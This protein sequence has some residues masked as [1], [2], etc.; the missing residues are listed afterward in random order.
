MKTI[1]ASDFHAALAAQGVPREHIALKCPVCA[2]VQS[3]GEFRKA[4]AAASPEHL[5]TYFGK[6]AINPELHFGFDCIGRVTG[7]GPWVKDEAPGRGCNWSLGGFLKAHRIE[8]TLSDGTAEPMF[9]P[10]TPEE[11]QAHMHAQP[12]AA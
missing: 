4:V 10:A 8:V 11:A 6:E 7:T 2:T 12:I 1:S 3:L 9:E 5:R